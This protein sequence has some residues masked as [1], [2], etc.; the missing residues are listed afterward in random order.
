MYRR[1]DGA[2]EENQNILKLQHRTTV[3]ILQRPGEDAFSEATAVLAVFHFNAV[4]GDFR[5]Q[6]SR[7]R[8]SISNLIRTVLFQLL[9]YQ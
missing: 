1:R 2:S 7:L 5:G 6:L 9:C 8:R 4:V 3:D